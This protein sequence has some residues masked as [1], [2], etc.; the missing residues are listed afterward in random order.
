MT[1]PKHPLDTRQLN[2]RYSVPMDDRE[3]QPFDFQI[4]HQLRLYLQRTGAVLDLPLK[5]YMVI[6][7]KHSDTDQQVD[8]DLSPFEAQ[9]HGV[10]RY[11]AII[12]ISDDRIVIKDFNSSN[13]T[14]LNGYEL[15]PMFA[16][17]L[18]HGDE[19]S[20]GRLI[21]AVHFLFE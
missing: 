7:R 14:L 2:R 17:R 19:L 6:G 3:T 15:R 5:R 9:T 10:S 12:Q 21:C 1:D 11:H 13:G 20:F 8:V 18:R 4:P 16:Y